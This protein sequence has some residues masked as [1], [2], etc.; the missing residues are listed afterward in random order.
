[1]LTHSYREG[2]QLTMGGLRPNTDRMVKV[3][4]ILGGLLLSVRQGLR[5]AAPWRVPVPMWVVF[6]GS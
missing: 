1:M 3:M 5:P 2:E 4:I 6:G